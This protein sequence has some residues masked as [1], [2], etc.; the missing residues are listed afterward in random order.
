MARLNRRLLLLL[1]VVAVIALVYV[2]RDKQQPPEARPLS[3]RL[4][5][6]GMTE[7]GG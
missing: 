1:L 2:M 5:Q 7:K 6:L 3:E 4:R